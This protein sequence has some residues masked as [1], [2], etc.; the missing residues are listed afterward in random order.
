MRCV[1]FPV[2]RSWGP[3]QNEVVIGRE[4]DRKALLTEAKLLVSL[5]AALTE[6]PFPSIQVVPL[7]QVFTQ[8][9]AASDGV[10]GLRRLTY[11]LPQLVE[12]RAGLMGCKLAL[13]INFYCGFPSKLCVLLVWRPRE[14]EVMTYHHFPSDSLTL[15]SNSQPLVVFALSVKAHWGKIKK[16]MDTHLH[17]SYSVQNLRMVI[18]FLNFHEPSPSM[19]TLS[20]SYSS[21]VI[22]HLNKAPGRLPLNGPWPA[23]CGAPTRILK[24]HRWQL[25]AWSENFGYICWPTQLSHQ[26][27]ATCSKHGMYVLSTAVITLPLSVCLIIS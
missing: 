20:Q 18:F 24:E 15:D 14:S 12:V 1:T 17:L 22:G 16:N 9:V 3:K 4:T 27:Q 6:F 26:Q 13:L 19:S 23:A 2:V 21:G 8:D 5:R 25:D 11:A 7:C 10:A